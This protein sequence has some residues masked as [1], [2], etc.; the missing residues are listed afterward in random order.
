M[1]VNCATCRHWTE[2]GASLGQCE[3]TETLLDK[4]NHRSSL[5]IAMALRAAPSGSAILYTHRTFCCNQFS[6]KLNQHRAAGT[7]VRVAATGLVRL[8][9]SAESGSGGPALLK[10]PAA[11]VTAHSLPDV[12]S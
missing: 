11:D 1:S 3:L 9:G 8:P 12:F 7:L 2:L 10:D 5:A 6:N 4:P